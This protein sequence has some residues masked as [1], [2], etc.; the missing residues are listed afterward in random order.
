MQRLALDPEIE[1]RLQAIF[2]EFCSIVVPADLGCY[3]N[4][5]ALHIHPCR[6]FGITRNRPFSGHMPLCGYYNYY[7]NSLPGD[8]KKNSI[9]RNCARS[10]HRLA[11]A[12][13][14]GK[15][16]LFDG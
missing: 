8:E 2:Q 12:V 15:E 6:S 1:Q 10:A 13:N 7:R 14:Q 5:Q 11:Q 16:V 4:G 9:C 3:T